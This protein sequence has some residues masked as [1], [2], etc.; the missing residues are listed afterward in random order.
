LL[1]EVPWKS[2]QKGFLGHVLGGWELSGTHRHQTGVAVTPVQNTNNNDPYCDGFFN[3]NFIGSTLDSC[4]PILS[5]PAAPFNTAGRYLNATQLINVSSCLSTAASIVG[6]PACPL[7]TPSSVHF[8]ANNI[9]AVNALCGGNPFACAV[10]RNVT[11]T[12]PRNQ[13]DLSVQKSFKLYERMSLTLRGDVINA[14]NYQ[15]YGAPG[16]NI[17]NKNAAGLACPTPVSPTTCTGPSSGIPAPSTFGE[18]WNNTGTFR[19][20]LVSAH[21]TF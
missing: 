11:R 14:F 21:V 6:T 3:I 17:N 7:I 12:Q 20:I 19:S 10:S 15:F 16:L 5:N 1:Y 13:V 8:I 4:R 2:S 18:V 9:Y